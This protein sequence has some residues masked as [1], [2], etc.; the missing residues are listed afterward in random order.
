MA[1]FDSF[2]VHPCD[3]I[4]IT[5]SDNEFFNFP[6]GDAE[7]ADPSISKEVF[8]PISPQSEPTGTQGTSQK[9]NR[10]ADKGQSYPNQHADLVS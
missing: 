6:S 7:E 8:L 5:W 9:K 4:D 2:V 10:G 1:P 3:P